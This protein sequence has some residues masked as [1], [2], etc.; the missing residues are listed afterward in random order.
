MY[1]NRSKGVIMLLKASL[2]VSSSRDRCILYL[3]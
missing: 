1:N 2:A 3:Q